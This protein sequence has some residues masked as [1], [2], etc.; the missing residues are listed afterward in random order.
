MVGDG[1]TT[2]PFTAGEARPVYRAP[3]GATDCHHHIYDDRFA[4][5]ARAALRPAAATVAMYRRLREHLGLSRSVVVQPSTYGT[6]NACLMDA[7]RQL[8]DAARGVAVID[9]ATDDVALRAMDEAGV[10]GIRFNLARPAGAAADALD[11]LARRVAPL[12]W[13]VQL[14]APASRIAAMAAQLESLPVPLVIDHLGRFAQPGAM[15]DA[16]WPVL[17]RLVDGGRAWVKL[18]GAYHDSADGAPDYADSGALTR[19]WLAAAP[20]RVVWGTDWPHPAATAGEKPLPDDARLLDLLAAW[21]PSAEAL[22]RVL[23]D[24][25]VTLYGFAPI[26]QS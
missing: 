10:R 18:S 26:S 20:E 4:P 11:V 3:P 17:R 22:R 24:N 8:G 16:A 2:V 12:G 19:A 25:P 23:V 6:D 9:E 1:V 15:E 14:H 13:H 21:A 7:L 5:D